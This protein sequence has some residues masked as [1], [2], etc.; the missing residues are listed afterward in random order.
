MKNTAFAK[1][2]NYNE[3][4]IGKITEKFELACQKILNVKKRL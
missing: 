1:L 3:L 2:K 4:C